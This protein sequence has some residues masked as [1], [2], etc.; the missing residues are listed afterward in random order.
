M[1]S[2][3]IDTREQ[4]PYSFAPEDATVLRRKLVTGD[5]SLDGFEYLVAVERKSLE[6]YA[7]SVI[8]NRARF[9]EEMKRMSSIR[10]RCVVVEGS[11]DDVSLGE[12]G[13]TAHPNSIMGATQS[14][15]VDFHVPVYFCGSRQ[16]A[17]WFTLSFLQRVARCLE[18]MKDNEAYTDGPGSDACNVDP[19][20][21]F[22]Y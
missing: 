8:K 5:Y 16:S 10:Y 3:V 14:L 4:R 1:L 17:C 15:I 11:V 18:K 6:D 12:Y 19:E 13:C 22:P 2:I 21:T 9:L 7:A 20:E